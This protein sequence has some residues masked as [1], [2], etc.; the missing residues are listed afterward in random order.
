MG[1]KPTKAALGLRLGRKKPGKG[2][3]PGKNQG[4]GGSSFFK[5]YPF[6]ANEIFGGKRLLSK[7]E[8]EKKGALSKMPGGGGRGP[9]RPL[10]GKKG[11]AMRGGFVQGLWP[12]GA[13]DF[14]PRM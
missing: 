4:A 12:P 7:S 13:G 1:P 6:D 14:W 9:A 3:A 5:R 10:G 11:G 8:R 2:W